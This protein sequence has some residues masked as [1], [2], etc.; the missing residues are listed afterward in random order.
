[1]LLIASSRS[2]QAIVEL[3]FSGCTGRG[4][5]NGRDDARITQ[6]MLAELMAPLHVGYSFNPLPP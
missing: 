4:L 3:T 1:M 5:F 6:S 2:E